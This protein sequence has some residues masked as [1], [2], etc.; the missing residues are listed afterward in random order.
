MARCSTCSG[1]DCPTGRSPTGCSSAARPSSTTPA[2]SLPSSACAA[3]RRPPRTRRV[4]QRPCEIGVL[5]DPLHRWGLLG[6]VIAAGIPPI[7]TYTFEFGPV[8]IKGTL[9]P[10][11]GFSAA[12]APRRTVLDQILVDA[13]VRAGSSC[14]NASC[15]RPRRSKAKP[16]G[17]SATGCGRRLTAWGRR[18]GRSPRST[19]S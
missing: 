1:M 18:S 13:A 8:A 15:R 9:H 10:A 16:S 11:E 5:P 7:E 3:A 17:R 19:N 14:G 4:R 12:Y 6:E 2:T